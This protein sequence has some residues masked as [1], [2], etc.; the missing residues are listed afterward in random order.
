[1]RGNDSHDHDQN[2]IE[3]RTLLKASA[4]L[5]TLW[6]AGAS[7]GTERARALPNR[8]EAADDSVIYQYFHTEW[9]EIESD[10]DRLAD[11]GIDAIWIPQPVASKLDWDDQ[12]YRDQDGFYE[13][14]ESEY[15]RERDPHPPLGYQPVDLRDFDSAHGTGAEL[16]SL[17]ETCHDNDIEVVVDVVLNHMANPQGP[18][19]EIDW[20]QFDAGEHFHDNG[21]IGEDCE[22]DGEAAQYECDLLGLPSL[23]VEHPEVQAAHEAYIEAIADLGADGLRFDAAAHVWPWYFEEMVHPIADRH[24]LWRVGEVWDEGDVGRLLEFAN[25]GM[26][27]FDFPLYAAIVDTFEGGSMENLSQNA[28]RGV[29][30]TNPDAAVTFVQNHDTVGPGVEPNEGE[31][32]EVELAEAFVLAYA[33]QPTLYRSGA[34]DRPEFEDSDLQD[35]VWVAQTLARGNVIDREV[36]H[37]AYVFER[38]GN[39]LAGINKSETAATYTVE[40]SWSDETLVD[41]A[42]PGEAVD[43]DASGEVTIEVPPEGWVMYGTG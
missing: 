41:H 11:L 36:T 34:D 23:D 25:T 7:F 43:V 14:E 3:R 33:G 24:G 17:I 19:G 21:T 15:G 22:L 16:E 29:V 28:A 26:T 5:G 40:T 20:P 39:L 8:P 4:A 31:G 1:M 42:G 9:T 2:G 12:T 13:D 37:E 6:A 30:H 18:D 32:I 10:V 35:L 38:E 27:V